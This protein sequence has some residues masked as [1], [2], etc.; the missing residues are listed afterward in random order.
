M[1]RFQDGA[2]VGRDNVTI[3]TD[4]DEYGKDW[5]VQGATDG[6]LFHGPSPYP[7]QCNLPSPKNKKIKLWRLE[8]S[9][10]SK[11]EAMQACAHWGSEIMDCVLD[12]RIS[13]DLV[14]ALNGPI[15]SSGDCS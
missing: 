8:E 15:N 7:K 12:V 14:V 1:G 13:G 3:H 2:L 9:I 10:I 6:F 11:E 5:Q 4:H